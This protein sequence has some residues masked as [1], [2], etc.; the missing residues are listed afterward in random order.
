M[1]RI[2]LRP[3]LIG[4]CLFFIAA[5]SQAATLTVTNTA[6]GGNG[7][8]RQA[9]LD[10]ATNA[11]ANTVTFSIPTT[12]PGF[13]SVANRFTIALTSALPS[14]PLA[15]FSLSNTQPQAVT[16]K[17]DNTFRIF[18]FVDS[19]VVIFNNLTIS[20]GSSNATALR[21]R[22]RS[23]AGDVTAGYGGGIYMGNSSTLN[24]NNCVVTGNTAFING[25]GIYMANSA[26]AHLSHSTVS[27]NSTPN[28][29][30]GGIFI[31]D[32]GTLNIDSSTVSGNSAVSGGGVYNGTS[33]TINATSNTFNGNTATGPGG[34]IIN[35]ATITLTNNT[36]TGNT[37][38]SGGGIYNAF[39]ATLD[40]N[41]V[42]LN[43][44][45]PGSDLYSASGSPSFTGGYNLIGNID[46]STGLASAPN[47]S[48]TTSNPLDPMLGPL[49]NN[50][51]TTFTRAL[52][53]GSPAIDTG[54][55]TIILDQRG[56]LRPIDILSVPNGTGNAADI[57]AFEAQSAPTSADATVGGRVTVSS[58]RCQ[59]GLVGARVTMTDMNG[60][61]RTIVTGRGGY[62]QFDDV[63]TGS[64]YILSVRSRLYSF[65]PRVVT[66]TDTL[67]DVDLVSYSNSSLKCVR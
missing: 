14:I 5:G 25:G 40:N 18:Q 61:A 16:V 12:D 29:N 33:G 3:T 57:G 8:L 49:Q 63:E 9:I 6:D 36:V 52:H 55:S 27:G 1:L 22:F 19:A 7:S 35:T 39:T 64:T 65:D 32:S 58:E 15:P 37:A 50:G 26:T 4:I 53:E 34:A 46:G 24:L 17:G 31:F 41:I 30:G 60:T 2:I 13:D 51:G 28:G 62:Y 54:T 11:E 10:A 44:A 67:S 47:I 38:G 56:F 21:S 42:A 20:N 45:S 66:V 23:S 59:S 48:G 43:T